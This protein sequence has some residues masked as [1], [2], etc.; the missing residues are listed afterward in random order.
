MSAELIMVIA[1]HSVFN[2]RG[3]FVHNRKYSLILKDQRNIASKREGNLKKV[4][5]HEVI[6]WLTNCFKTGRFIP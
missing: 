5:M 1:L 6:I 3:G 2:D 4:W